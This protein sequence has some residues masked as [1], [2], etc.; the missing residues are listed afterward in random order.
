MTYLRRLP[1]FEFVS[2]DSLAP[3]CALKAGADNGEM[4]LVA[5]GTDALLQMRR[6]E[7]SPRCVVGM[8]AIGELDYIRED[9]DGGLSIGAMTPLETLVSAPL[10]KG[11]FDVLRDTAGQIGGVEL[12]N[13][14]TIGGNIA[15]ALPCADM[16]PPLMTLGAEVKLSSDAG[17]RWVPLDELY[18]GYGRMAISDNEVLSEIRVPR[19]ARAS[20]SVYLKYHDRQ[21]M[22]MT[23]IGVGVHVELVPESGALKDVRLAY[24]NGAPTTF[25]AR[26]TEEVL[27]GEVLSDDLLFAAAEAAG[28]EA[29]PRANSWRADPEYRLA[30]IKSMTRRAVRRA[31]EKALAR[32]EAQS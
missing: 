12:R 17:E 31:C 28:K 6:R 20:G 18:A 16:P 23:V 8:K 27:R 4:M 3:L 29:V 7:V 14:A 22:D 1:K 9:A 11:P 21:S 32:G 19:P 5:G 24:A 10:L 15:G 30:L 26:K 13:V 2:P 25:R